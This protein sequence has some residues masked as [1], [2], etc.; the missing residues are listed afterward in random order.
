MYYRVNNNFSIKERLVCA[1]I[2]LVITLAGG[3]MFCISAPSL[4]TMVAAG[5]V[6]PIS[7]MIASAIYLG[8]A[9][10]GAN[11]AGIG[12]RMFIASIIG[13]EKFFEETIKRY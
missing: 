1:L 8:F 9:V 6:P 13:S 12:I 2:S 4:Y 7:I 3:T 5:H 11:I 10:E